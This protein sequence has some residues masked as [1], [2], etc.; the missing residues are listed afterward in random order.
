MKASSALPYASKRAIADGFA[1]NVT[2]L[3]QP[4]GY[5]KKEEG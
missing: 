3:T 1:H 4:E 2:I 5:R